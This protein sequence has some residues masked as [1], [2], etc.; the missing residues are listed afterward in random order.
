[1]FAL[2]LKIPHICLDLF[3]VV[4]KVII[5]TLSE[6]V[7]EINHALTF[8]FVAKLVVQSKASKTNRTRRISGFYGSK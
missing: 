7:H 2:L 8:P 6:I 3:L 5:R 1:M 4:L